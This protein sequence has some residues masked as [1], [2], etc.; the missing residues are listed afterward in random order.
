[1]KKIY[2]YLENYKSK[3]WIILLLFSVFITYIL[4]LTNI[5]GLLSDFD[6]SIMLDLLF[7]YQGDEF[8]NNFISVTD[9]QLYYYQMIHIVDYIFI[10]SFYPLL[11]IILA[12]QKILKNYIILIIPLMAMFFDLLEN[13]IIDFHMNFGVSEFLGSLSGVSTLIKFLTIFVTLILITILFIRKKI[14]K[15]KN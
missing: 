13:L 1:M 9:I 15:W 3:N 4:M 8:I 5:F 2:T 6:R 11:F 12:K 7:F 14:L 10:L